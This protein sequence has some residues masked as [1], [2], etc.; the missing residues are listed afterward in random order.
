MPFHVRSPF[1][2]VIAT[3]FSLAVPEGSAEE[4]RANAVQI[5]AYFEQNVGQAD[6]DSHFLVR[7]SGFDGEM[8]P[9][10]VLMRSRDG[11]R[12]VLRFVGGLRTQP[13]GEAAM[14]ARVHYLVGPQSSWHRNVPTYASVRYQ[15]VYRGIDA[16]FYFYGTGTYIEYD[17][18]VAPGADP[19]EVRVR[20]DGAG[21]PRLKPD[22]S[23]A[24]LVGDDELTQGRPFLYQE[25]ASGRVRVDGRYRVDRNG[26]VRV[27]V[28]S[29]DRRQPLVI[30]PTL[31]FSTFAAGALQDMALDPDGNI[32]ITGVTTSDVV[33]T[34]GAYRTTFAG[35]FITKL[36]PTG[37]EVIY[38]TFLGGS[39]PGN[40][41]AITADAAGLA[42]VTGLTLAPDFPVTPGAAGPPCVPEAGQCVPHGFVTKL[43]A[44]GS[45][46]VFST[47][48]GPL[49]TF[50]ELGYPTDIAL[51]A[52][53]RAHVVGVAT[54]PSFPI[55]AGAWMRC[56]QTQEGFGNQN[57]FLAT[58][59]ASATSFTYATC[60]G[61]SL[62]DMASAVA[63]G[64]DGTRVVT[65][66]TG[67]SDFPTVAPLQ[68]RFGGIG[69]MF[70]VK[71]DPTG[72]VN[73]S[74]TFGGDGD[75]HGNGAA[76]A[77]DGSIWIAG[78]TTSADV[79][80]DERTVGSLGSSDALF[81]RL[82]PNGQNL[83]Y[84]VRVG[85][86][87]EDRGLRVAIGPNGGIHVAGE[88][89]S[90]NFPTTEDAF[91][92]RLGSNSYTDAFYG[93][94][95]ESAS[96]FTHLTLFGG[97][98]RD[99]LQALAVGPG[100]EG[101]LAG[102]AGGTIPLRNASRTT[103]RSYVVRFDPDLIGTGRQKDIV[104]HA[105]RA[106]TFGLWR[107]EPDATAAGGAKVRHADAGLTISTP[108]AAPANYFE[109]AFFAQAN[110]AYRLWLRGKADGDHWANDSVFVQF[111]DAID[112][113]G[114]ATWGIG[115]TSATMVQIERC[116]GCRLRGWGWNDNGSSLMPQDRQGAFVR[117][118]NDG[119]HTIRIQTRQDGLAIDQVVLSSER[120][121]TTAPG[122][123]RDDATVLTENPGADTMTCA[124]GEIVLHAADAMRVGAWERVADTAAASAARITN[125]N[126]GVPR[127]P[128]PLAAP[129]DHVELTFSARANVDYRLWIRGR[130]ESNHWSN[131]SAWV[132]FSDSVTASGTPTWRIGTTSAT[133]YV[134]EDCT[135]CPIS[136]W[137]WNDNAYGGTSLGA[138]VRFA[139]SGAHVIR[140]QTRQDGLSIDQIV[141]SPVEY[142]LS[143]PGAVRNDTTILDECPR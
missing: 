58:L 97:A 12:R 106:A 123:D 31:G 64:P 82:S 70:I 109:L 18:I 63:V 92:R 143:P 8:T 117:F 59:N 113:G 140:I 34:P 96:E 79:P 103:G 51:D 65:G 136:S 138:P 52:A 91:Q 105:H 83:F 118:A 46:L 68:S 67:S 134:L 15:N 73:F 128:A 129:V 47:L 80:G 43:N 88:S 100:G 49:G 132:Q 125:P 98:G 55:T 38:S 108:L 115:T 48:I 77:E 5:P 99:N 121:V 111:S 11:V 107:V 78:D 89:R 135:H 10:G 32:Y 86:T 120:F 7:A 33:A 36:D 60:F 19:A 87:R 76:I 2:L 142:F 139:T 29:H 102:E 28:G 13:R 62:F 126:A 24:W 45:D 75:E 94:L 6:R 23:L 116:V 3:A 27:E 21:V 39:R 40:T 84:S 130:A 85:G 112:P 122:A 101:Y 114:R 124:A 119:M 141:L 72:T 22:G 74:T 131:D 66:V 81:L 53:G 110:V 35:S 50:R 41:T 69:D 37:S 71:F 1:T 54:N 95:A 20:L 133:T 4:R 16:V 127:T 56:T 90:A 61:G 93:T 17:L 9:E 14:A 26:D 30:D 44:A 104:L 42:Y 137:G 25:T 57:G